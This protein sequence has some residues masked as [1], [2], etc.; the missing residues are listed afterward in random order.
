MIMFLQIFTAALIIFT[1]GEK[2]HAQ[3][4]EGYD[5]ET[6]DPRTETQSPLNPDKLFPAESDGQPTL[7]LEAETSTRVGV[8]EMIIPQQNRLVIGDQSI[9]LSSDVKVNTEK[10]RPLYGVNN[11]KRGMTVR[12]N[13]EISKGQIIATEITELNKRNKYK[14]QR[15]RKNNK[16]NRKRDRKNNQKINNTG[17]NTY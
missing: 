7:L 17:Y 9:S 5:Q 2:S 4:Y 3:Y 16:T 14:N 11:L 10:R 1:L 6:N 15:N 12:L 8:I 13:T